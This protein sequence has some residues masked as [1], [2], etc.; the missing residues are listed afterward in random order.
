MRVDGEVLDDWA[1]D[2]WRR[3][4]LSIAQHFIAPIIPERAWPGLDEPTCKSG[5]GYECVCSR[6]AWVLMMV[7]E[8]EDHGRQPGYFD[9]TA[10]L[11]WASTK[12]IWTSTKK[13][14]RREER[15]IL[16]LSIQ[17]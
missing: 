14:K 9:M 7:E 4:Y 1:N 15:A 12:D 17:E 8:R 13:E 2:I 16:R 11:S 5:S 3:K 6:S 10:R